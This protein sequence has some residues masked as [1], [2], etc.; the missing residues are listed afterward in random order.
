MLLAALDC[1]TISELGEALGSI[2]R[3]RKELQ[4]DPELYDCVRTL[5]DINK[6]LAFTRALARRIKRQR[7]MLNHGE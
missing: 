3:L 2:L 1:S 7:A 6:D 4:L 5:L